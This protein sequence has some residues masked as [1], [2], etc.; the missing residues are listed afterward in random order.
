MTAHYIS[1]Q[2]AMSTQRRHLAIKSV[3]GLQ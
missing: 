3:K 2:T 1:T